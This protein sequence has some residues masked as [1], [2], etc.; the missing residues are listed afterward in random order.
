VAFAEVANRW[1]LSGIQLYGV[2]RRLNTWR[3][4]LS[5]IC[6]RFVIVESLTPEFLCAPLRLFA[7]FAVKKAFKTTN[8]KRQGRKD[9]AKSDHVT[10]SCTVTFNRAE[11]PTLS[12]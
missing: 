2:I 5:F 7:Y 4:A 9:P 1:T 8:R 12:M 10:A 11:F 6:H 3:R